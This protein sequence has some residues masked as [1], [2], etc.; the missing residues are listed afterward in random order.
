[1]LRGQNWK[2]EAG[3]RLRGCH[4]LL[5]RHDLSDHGVIA[6]NG[7]G[8]APCGY[9]VQ[10]LAG[11][12]GEFCSADGLHCLAPNEYAWVRILH[13]LSISAGLAREYGLIRV[14]RLRFTGQ[15]HAEGG[16]KVLVKPG[17]TRSPYDIKLP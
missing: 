2:H 11:I 3:Q 8:L 14:Q 4:G 10:Y 15:L 1:M 12:S 5:W 13:E 6:L 17:G 9:A 16:V 7:D